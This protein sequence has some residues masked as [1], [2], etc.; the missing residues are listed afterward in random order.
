MLGFISLTPCPNIAIF[1]GDERNTAVNERAVTA[2]RL[3]CAEKV[4]LRSPNAAK[5]A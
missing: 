4:H 5:P 2:V 1:I 3:L